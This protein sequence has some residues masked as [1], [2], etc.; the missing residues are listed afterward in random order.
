[1]NTQQSQE[2]I[3]RRREVES[4]TGLSRSAVY[5]LMAQ[6]KFPK[7]INLGSGHAVGWSL[8]EV[9]AWIETKKQERNVESAT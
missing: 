8:T 9:M 1:M 6:G 5:L 3:I 4:I 7:A 2:R